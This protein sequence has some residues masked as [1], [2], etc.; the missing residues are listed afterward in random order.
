MSATIEAGL[1]PDVL[2]GW[3][4]PVVWFDKFPSRTYPEGQWV[5][6]AYGAG[7][8]ANGTDPTRIL[9]PLTRPECRAQLARVLA[10][11]LRCPCVAVRDDLAR[12]GLPVADVACVQCGETGWTRPPRPCFHLLPRVEGGSLPDE[13]VQHAPVLLVAHARDVAAGGPGI[14]GVLKTW[15]PVPG[16]PD[17]GARWL[18]SGEPL[19]AREG[20]YGSVTEEQGWSLVNACSVRAY[21]PETCDAGMAAADRAALAH[22]YAL[23]DG[24]SV[25]VP[26]AEGAS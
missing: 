5:T 10:T 17:S 23:I 13:Y 26:G 14:V 12:R 18:M 7:G 25:R 1:F 8:M 20:R 9:L 6:S 15:A 16:Y 24:A 11:G 21:G 2:D 19:E 4:G 22:H 3:T